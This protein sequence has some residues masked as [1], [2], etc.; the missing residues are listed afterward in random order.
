MSVMDLKWPAD[1]FTRMGDRI[2]ALGLPTLVV[3][4]GGYAVDEIGG[5]AVNF[6]LG[7]GNKL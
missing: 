3:L 5:N 1:D 6:L 4:E 7:L 2:G